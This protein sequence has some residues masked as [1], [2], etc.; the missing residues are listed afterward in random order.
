MPVVRTILVVASYRI[1]AY[2]FA[3]EPDHILNREVVLVAE[4]WAAHV[5]KHFELT[6]KQAL[7]WPR[8]KSRTNLW[9]GGCL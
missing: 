8:Q 1:N 4:V 3:P 9:C 5:K 7:M 6:T 2:I